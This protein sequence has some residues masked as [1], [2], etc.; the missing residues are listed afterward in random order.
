MTS[1]GKELLDRYVKE[2]IHKMQSNEVTEEVLKFFSVMARFHRYSLGN[3]I[4]I[5]SQ[6]P[7]ATR[8]AGY[9]TWQKFK[10]QV[11]RG[12]KA[13]KIL[14]PSK[15]KKTVLN[16]ET[17][18]EEEEEHLYFR[19]VNVFDVSQTEGEPLPDL[20]A[21]GEKDDKVIFTRLLEFAAS[22]NIKV[23]MRELNG[24]GGYSSGG[25][26]AIETRNNLTRQTGTLIHELAHEILHQG[27]DAERP[28]TR[29]QKEIEAE[30]T[31]WIV[32]QYLG[33]E[34]K[35]PQYL[36]AWGADEKTIYA[37]LERIRE[38]VNVMIMGLEEESGEVGS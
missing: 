30:V 21:V 35:S 12:E 37:S 5:F 27:E 33:V 34:R 20:M 6:Y 17:G 28:E 23:A 22:Q 32:S 29:Q 7:N 19:T 31:A 24:A 4:L 26:I 38:A 2:L 10:R 36:K 13:I 18:K 1:K 11:Q 15:Y 16:E 8:V 9:H 25:L 14:A 3:Q